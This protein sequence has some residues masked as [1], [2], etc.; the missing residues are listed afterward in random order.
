MSPLLVQR[1]LEEPPLTINSMVW[2]VLLTM[3]TADDGNIMM[4][5]LLLSLLLPR[6]IHD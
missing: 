6:A 3:E 4:P 1:R 2:D 5:L